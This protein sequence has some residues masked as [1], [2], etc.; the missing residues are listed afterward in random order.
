MARVFRF[1]DVLGAE[2]HA[3]SDP[4]DQLPV[5]QVLQ[6]VTIGSSRMRVESVTFKGSNGPHKQFLFDVRVRAVPAA[7]H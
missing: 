6:V 7:G 1:V 2:L 5:P 4:N 3:I